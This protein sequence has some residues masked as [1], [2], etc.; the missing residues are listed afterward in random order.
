MFLLD[1]SAFVFVFVFLLDLCL[2]S[3][4]I[5]CLFSKKTK[6]RKCQ[7]K[8]NVLVLKSGFVFLLLLFKA[9]LDLNSCDFLCLNFFY[10]VKINKLIF[11]LNLDADVAFLNVKIDFF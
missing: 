6:K 5:L 10:L 7:I 2:C 4:L 1:L 3:C 11:F 9:L 8:E